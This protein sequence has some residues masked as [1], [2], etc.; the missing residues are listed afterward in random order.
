MCDFDI[1]GVSWKKKKK[2]KTI[3]RVRHVK[4]RILSGFPKKGYFCVLLKTV[5]IPSS[6]SALVSVSKTE[7]H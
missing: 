2:V 5:I 4:A 7:R 6:K 1:Q 3:K